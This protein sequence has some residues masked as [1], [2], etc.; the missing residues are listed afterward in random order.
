ML[1]RVWNEARRRPVGWTG[2]PP[3][4]AFFSVG[5]PREARRVIES[6]ERSRSCE[7]FR[8]SVDEFG[9]EFLCDRGWREWYDREGLDVMGHAPRD[10]EGLPGLAERSE[11]LAV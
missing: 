9:L 8:S 11:R 7:P 6:L 2:N 5:S 3:R 1:F 10:G 4:R